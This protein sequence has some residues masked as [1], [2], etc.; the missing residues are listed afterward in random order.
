MASAISGTHIKIRTS[1][2]NSPC[3]NNRKGDYLIILHSVLHPRIRFWGINVGRAGKLH[4][5]RVFSLLSLSELGNAGALHCTETFEGV[6]VL[7]FLLGDSAYPLL[8]WLLK[9]YAEEGESHHSSLTSTTDLSQAC[10][11]IEPAFG[12]LK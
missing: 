9:L 4:D 6:D 12:C 5:A 8:A 11:T 7:H 10:M 3:Y 1:P 2:N